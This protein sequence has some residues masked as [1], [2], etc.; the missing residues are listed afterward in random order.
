MVLENFLVCIG[1]SLAVF[2]LLAFMVRLSNQQ[3]T[4]AS[5]P[6]MGTVAVVLGVAGGF[7]LPQTHWWPMAQDP[8]GTG[9]VIEVSNVNEYTRRTRQSR[10]PVL[11]GVLSQEDNRFASDRASMRLL[12]TRLRGEGQV[13]LV[14]NEHARTITGQ[15]AVTDFPT[16]ILYNRGSELLRVRGPKSVEELIQ[17]WGRRL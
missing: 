17:I 4:F 13:L 8:I 9:T 10:R 7:V 5:F 14:V 11:V 16:Y 12:A 6:I 3:S 2:W 15:I 1:V